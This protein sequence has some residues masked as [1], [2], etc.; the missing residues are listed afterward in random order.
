MRAIGFLFLFAAAGA[1]DE[2]SL[3]KA[4]KLF[5]QKSYAP[6]AVLLDWGYRSSPQ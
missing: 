2:S 3:A 1:S 5:D 6:A 4:Q